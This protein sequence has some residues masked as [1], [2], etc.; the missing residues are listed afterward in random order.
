MTHTHKPSEDKL[1]QLPILDLKN[2]LFRLGAI[3]SV[4]WVLVG[5]AFLWLSG[6]WGQQLKPNEWGDV[7]AGLAAPMAF[8]WLVLGFLQQGHELKLSTRALLLQVDELK[9]T[10]EHQR[11]LVEVTRQQVAASIRQEEEERAA[12]RHAAQP[13]FVLAPGTVSGGPQGFRYEVRLSNV[14]AVATNVAISVDG[15]SIG[16]VFPAV[17]LQEA[18]TITL[19]RS[20]S[21]AGNNATFDIRYTDRSGLPG[22]VSFIARVDPSNTMSFQLHRPPQ[23]RT[24]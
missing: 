15:T 7:F 24:Q 20:S 16:Y 21:L 9:N 23:L 12:R 18:R 8:F 14:G 1:E 6:N 2:P 13:Q 4:V 19:E 5:V 11:Q 17:G 10:V 3:A 22:E